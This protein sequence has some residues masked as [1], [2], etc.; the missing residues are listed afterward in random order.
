ME[1]KDILGTC[2]LTFKQQIA[3]LIEMGNKGKLLITV[4]SELVTEPTINI[5]QSKLFEINNKDLEKQIKQALKRKPTKVIVLEYPT[6]NSLIDNVSLLDTINFDWIISLNEEEQQTVSDYCDEKEVFGLVYNQTAD[7]KWVVSLQNPSAVLANGVEINGSSTIDG[8]GL[9]PIIGGLLAGCPYTNAATS[10]ILDELESVE[11]PE[12]ITQGQ[13]VL[14]NEEEG[15]RVATAVNTLLTLHD[16]ETQDMKDIAIMEGIR[17]YKKDFQKAF[18]TGYKG[19]KNT[20]DNQQ[21]FI[22]AGKGYL[23]NLEDDNVLILDPEYNNDIF[24]N[25][26]RVRE[27]WIASGKKEE[28][29]NAMS[30]LEISKLTYKKIVV[31]KSKVKFLNAIDECEIEVEMF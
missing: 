20:Y 27:L 14:Y 19:K 1:L 21:L 24:I 11:M 13:F 15:V 3:D 9:L 8:V 2:T 12:E 5:Y 18:R 22:S 23:R 31:L 10:Y 7:S 30:D 4:K 17:R 28:E 29:I 6:S 25:T 16:N 26:D